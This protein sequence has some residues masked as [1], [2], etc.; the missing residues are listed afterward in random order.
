MPSLGCKERRDEASALLASEG[1]DE[2]GR[3]SGFSKVQDGASSNVH[4]KID[5][6]AQRNERERGRVNEGLS[7]GLVVVRRG[8]VR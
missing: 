7:C 3:C 8:E 1:R 6:L 4:V 2:I 5:R